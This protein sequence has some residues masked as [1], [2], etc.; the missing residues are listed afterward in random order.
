MKTK[1]ILAGTEYYAGKNYFCVIGNRTVCVFCRRAVH[2][3]PNGL[4]CKWYVPSSPLR[5]GGVRSTPGWSASSK[6]SL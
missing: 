2:F 4:C 1:I 5:R 3:V 6:Y